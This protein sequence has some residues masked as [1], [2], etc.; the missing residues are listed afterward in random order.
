VKPFPHFPVRLIAASALLAVACGGVSEVPAPDDGGGSS[1]TS[2]PDADGASDDSSA[3][4][5]SPSAD[6][7]SAPEADGALDDS[8]LGD[9]SAPD[10]SRSNDDAGGSRYPDEDA[11]SAADAAHSADAGD[12][13]VLDAGAGD[14]NAADAGTSDTD[15]S[16]ANASEADASDA[17]LPDATVTDAG[18]FEDAPSGDSTLANAGDDAGVEDASTADVLEVGDAGTSG[19]AAIADA[20]IVDAGP[21]VIPSGAWLASAP[22]LPPLPP[23]TAPTVDSLINVTLT[24]NDILYD[25]YSQLLYASIPSSFGT[26]GNSVAR[27][28]PTT[29]TIL[30]FVNVGSEPG[31]LAESADGHYL[32]VGLN[33]AAAVRRYVLATQTPDIQF[34]LVPTQYDEGPNLAISIQALPNSPGSVVVVTGTAQQAGSAIAIYDD[35]V[36]R[37]AV[38]YADADGVNAAVPSGSDSLAFEAFGASVGD[39]LRSLCLNPAGVFGSSTFLYETG[40]GIPYAT[41]AYSAGLFYF[42]DGKVLNPQ[43]GAQ[44]GLY[45]MSG[46]F[47]LEPSVNRM[48]YLTNGWSADGGAYGAQISAYN[49]A[50]FTP[51]ASTVFDALREDTS[52]RLVRWGRYGFAFVS[53]YGAQVSIVRS[54]IV[55]VQP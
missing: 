21:C 47:V 22:A 48:Y 33:G 10:G 20:S 11:A 51:L 12:A 50:H 1:D 14:A 45:Q 53:N 36:P 27:I 6:A 38:F 54:S 5:G 13:T 32:Y 4:D 7:A 43:T 46:P 55:P 8:S 35:G 9:S 34:S 49:Q 52:I 31:V 24:V 2:A 29:G 28:D 39:R 41:Y 16:D 26:N 44:A 25:P 3:S 15:A 23:E 18:A 19:D 40:S 17:G 30:G 37:Q 42:P